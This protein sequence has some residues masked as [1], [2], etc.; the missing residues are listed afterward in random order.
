MKMRWKI[1]GAVLATGLLTGVAAVIWQWPGKTES[2]ALHFVTEPIARRDIV[3]SISAIGTVEPEELINVGAQVNGKI[4]AFGKDADGK[5]IDYGSLVRRGMVLAQIDDV[6]YKAELQQSQATKEQAEAAILTAQAAIQ[7]AD[8]NLVLAK[9]NFDRAQQL[10]K[11]GSMSK[12][13]YDTNEAAYYSGLAQVSKSKAQLAQGKASLSIAE[14]SLIK[15]MRNVEYCQITSPVDGIVIDRRVS[16]G[17]TVVSNQTASS[18]FLVATDFKRMQIWVSVNEADIG[19]VKP[20]MPVEFTCDAYPGKIF[21]GEVFRVRMNATLS[22][23]VVTYIVEVNAPND[24]GKLLPYLTANVKFIL[25]SRRQVLAVPT[26][27]LRLAPPAQLLAAPAPEV[28]AGEAVL[29]VGQGSLLH[30]V[31][32]KTGLGSGA[33]TEIITDELHENDLIA[34]KIDSGSAAVTP[35]TVGSTAASSGSDSQ[36]PFMPKLPKMQSSGSAGQ[37]ERLQKSGDAVK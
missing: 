17:Q 3:R 25:A 35:V 29:W 13:D 16:I 11:Q 19:N 12:S 31:K 6:I 23:N 8:A 9:N 20:G 5:T 1:T 15:S 34:V 21:P 28:T 30:P 27:V 22:S 10:I 36:N 4:M 24:D 32:V 33:Y 37:R 14:A 18:I 7:E 2:S 26:T